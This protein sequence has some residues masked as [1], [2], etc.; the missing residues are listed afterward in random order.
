VNSK[1]AMLKPNR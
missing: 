1:I